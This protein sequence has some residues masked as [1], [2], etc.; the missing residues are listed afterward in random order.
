M[1]F[2]VGFILLVNSGKEEESFWFLVGLLKVK[3]EQFDTLEG[4][5]QTSFP[6]LLDYLSTFDSLLSTHLPSLKL[7]LDSIGLVPHL[8]ALKWFQTLYLYSFPF[9]FCLRA[10]DHYLA[11]GGRSFLLLLNLSICQLYQ[12]ELIK[13]DMETANEFFNSF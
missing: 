8:W 3:N 13:M 10:W 5:Y 9:S 12:D 6:L 1:N 11:D 2:M 7:H 4:L